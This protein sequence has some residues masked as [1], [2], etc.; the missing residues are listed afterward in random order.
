ML[1]FSFTHVFSQTEKGKKIIDG[2]FNV[3]GYDNY[4]NA[5]FLSYD[6]SSFRFHI[7]PGLGYFIKDNFA[8][9]AN[10]NFEVDNTTII[11][12]LPNN[13]PSLLTDKFNSINYGAGVFARYYKKIIDSLFFVVNACISYA[14]QTTSQEFSSN[15]PNYI[16]SSNDPAIQKIVGNTYSVA[17]TP[18]L[19]Y[20]LGP[21]L[22]I[23]TNFSSIYYENLSSKN[24]SVPT[25]NQIKSNNYGFNFN[26]TTFYLGLQYHF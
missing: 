18:E 13:M 23:S 4:N 7:V 3:A 21:K 25:I 8:I 6:S 22:G 9:G 19:V 2:Q 12:V 5:S 16:P 15:D 14:H 20:F 10:L 26:I 24:I 17:I 11:S 1:I